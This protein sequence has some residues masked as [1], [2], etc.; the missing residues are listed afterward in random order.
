METAVLLIIIIF[1]IIAGFFIITCYEI[2]FGIISKTYPS[3]L[4]I[5]FST[6]FI[7]YGNYNLS[8][9][10]LILGVIAQIKLIRYLEKINKM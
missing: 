6:L 7:M 9:I 10:L 5:L 1:L 4:S 8:I 3:I 2:I